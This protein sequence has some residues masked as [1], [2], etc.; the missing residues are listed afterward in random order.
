[1]KIVVVQCFNLEKSYTSHLSVFR[2]MMF[3]FDSRCNMFVTCWFMFR[4]FG[5]VRNYWTC[6]VILT[7][8]VL[9]SSELMKLNFKCCILS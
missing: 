7:S 4:M 9:V 6:R 2:D 5:F 3:L 8:L 1:M